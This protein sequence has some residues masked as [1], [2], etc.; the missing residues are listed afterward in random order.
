MIMLA[1]GGD[2]R[3]WKKFFERLVAGCLIVPSPG[4]E[5]IGHT[6]GAQIHLMVRD[7][8]DGSSGLIVFTSED[9]LRAWRQV[10]CP[11]FDMPSLKAINLR[12]KRNKDPY[13]STQRVRLAYSCVDATF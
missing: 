9:A 5:P 3:N 12:Y 1:R 7:A 13:L 6:D 4:A 11:Y 10:G 2:R 8:P